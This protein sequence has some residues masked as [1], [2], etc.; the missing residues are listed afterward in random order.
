MRGLTPSTSHPPL[1]TKKFPQ[2]DKIKRPGVD[3]GPFVLRKKATYTLDSAKTFTNRDIAT[4]MP[5]T[6]ANA[7]SLYSMIASTYYLSKLFIK[8][9]SLILGR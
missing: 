6:P 4:M 9:T 5:A 1:V 2:T 7:E 3:P 8:R